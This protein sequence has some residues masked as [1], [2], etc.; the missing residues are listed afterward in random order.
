MSC[1]RWRKSSQSDSSGGDR[2]EVAE[3]SAVVAVR[4][5]KEYAASLVKA[6]P[7]LFASECRRF[8]GPV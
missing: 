1:A 4:D 8:R 5:S 6:A 7:A 2:V 3:V